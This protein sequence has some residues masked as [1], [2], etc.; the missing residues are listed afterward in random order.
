M[1]VF[2]NRIIYGEKGEIQMNIVTKIKQD[3]KPSLMDLFLSSYLIS[4]RI[5]PYISSF[6]IKKKVIPNKITMHMIYSGII[7]AIFF[8][9]PNI[10][11]KGIG[12]IFIHLWFVLDCSDGE[13]A[14][15]TSTFS[16][17]GKE[18]DFMA[19]LI[20]H[21]LFGA[22]LFLSLWQLDRYN[23]FYLFALV[24][25][26]NFMDYGMR[27][28]LTLDI[29]LELRKEISEAA[30]QEKKW[31]LKKIILFIM[32]LAMLYPNFILFGV[33][34]YFIDYFTGLNILYWYLAS[35]VA[36]T[37]VFVLKEI[38]RLTKA[39]YSSK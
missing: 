28:V 4:Q 18:L 39:F 16:R 32:S 17:Y 12:A 37:G 19:H 3:N 24:I 8:A 33:L 11:L 1:R 6:Y 13:V 2:I 5:S 25:L 9:M 38:L 22:S 20:N 34:I 23:V 21:P 36:L 14:R 10:F 30:A 31:T 29:V 26:S 35:N 7:G 27:N 15:Y